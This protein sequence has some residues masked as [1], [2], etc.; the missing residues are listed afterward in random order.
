MED[1]KS[2]L[3]VIDALNVL[4]E[5][6]L[7]IEKAQMAG[8]AMLREKIESMTKSVTAEAPAGVRVER[9]IVTVSR[10]EIVP[11]QGKEPFCRTTFDR[12]G[13]EVRINIFSKSITE[14]IIEAFEGSIPCEIEYVREGRFDNLRGFRMLSMSEGMPTELEEETRP[15]F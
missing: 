7:K 8:F 2:I 11:R 10:Y 1:P 12:N 4:S 6:I 3:T 5:R 13:I 9:A 15:P 14:K